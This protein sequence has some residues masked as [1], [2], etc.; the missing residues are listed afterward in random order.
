MSWV[1]KEAKS[2]SYK[3]NNAA[4]SEYLAINS[5]QTRRAFV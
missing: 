1:K 2:S 3:A 4:K 5:A